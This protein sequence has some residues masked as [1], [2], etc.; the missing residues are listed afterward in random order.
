MKLSIVSP[1]FKAE[2]I[3]EELV[4][5]I[6]SVCSELGYDYEILLVEDCSPDLSWHEIQRECEKNPKVKGIKL[7][8]NFGQHAAITCGIDNAS[9]EYIIVM[10]C[11]LQ[12]D[13]KYIKD[14]VEQAE[15]G[16][17]IVY[18]VK[19]YRNHGKS[20]N[21]GSYLFNKV[22]NWLVSDQQHM[23]YNENIGSYSLISRKV[24]NAFLGVGDYRRHYL[25][26]LRFL[27]FQSSEI[28]IQHNQR[29]KGNSSYNLYKLLTH[30]LV[31]IVYQ[32]NRL[33]RLTVSV[34]ATISFL[35]G[36]FGIYVIVQALFF[37]SAPGWA[38]TIVV[39]LFMSGLIMLCVGI[40][41]LYIGSIAE[42]VRNRPIFI[43]DQKINDPIRPH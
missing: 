17:D 10:D 28:V 31:G 7:S 3:I 34:G 6:N 9:G 25:L 16:F 18:T 41:A 39:V 21:L 20:K 5:R 22:F 8:R 42:Q 30:A 40:S 35:S 13:P 14:L 38:S 15:K 33:L 37:T 12:D 32:S 1:V 27:G 43:I 24:A 36:L 4:K 11:D 23:S 19:E 29:F 2:G 26:V